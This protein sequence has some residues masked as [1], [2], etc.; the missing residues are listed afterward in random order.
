[1]FGFSIT[2]KSSGNGS[3]VLVVHSIFLSSVSTFFGWIYFLCW[4]T[5]IYPQVIQYCYFH[6]VRLC[7]NLHHLFLVLKFSYV[8]MKFQKQPFADV[9]ENRISKKFHKIHRKIPQ[10]YSPNCN[11]IK[12]TPVLVFSWEICEI[13]YNDCFCVFKIPFFFLNIS[14]CKKNLK[15]ALT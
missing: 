9:R 15:G 2:F 8:R 6:L 1:M 11:F 14:N 12:K 3:Y 13:F 5:S 7:G 10:H 4:T